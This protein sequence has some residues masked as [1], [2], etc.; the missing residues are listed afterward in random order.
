MNFHIAS[1]PYDISKFRVLTPDVIAVIRRDIAQ[2]TFPSWLER[3]PR[4]FGDPSHRKLKANQWRT[5]CTVSLVISL[6]RL[7]GNYGEST[8]EAVLLSNFIHLVVAVDLATRRSMDADRAERF[9]AHMFK[10]LEGL[11]DIFKHG[12]VPNH[13][14]SLHLKTFLLLFGPVHG[15][16]GFPFERY[17]GILQNLNTNN[18]PGLDRY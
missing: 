13:H 10:Y 9:D 2:T 18:L 11:Q 6:M 17:N 16:W 8:K 15:W 14:L 5:V 4:N 1:N 7:W 12:L 3:P